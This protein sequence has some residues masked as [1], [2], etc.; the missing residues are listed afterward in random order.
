MDLDLW[1]CFWNGKAY[2][3]AKLQEIDLNGIILVGKIP[4]LYLSN[5]CITQYI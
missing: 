1:D 4:V 5:Y 2:L 3:T